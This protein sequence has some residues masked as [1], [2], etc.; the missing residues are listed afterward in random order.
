MAEPVQPTS[1]EEVMENDD[2][3]DDDVGE[4]S[5]E[6]FRDILVVGVVFLFPKFMTDNIRKIPVRKI[7]VK[8]TERRLGDETLILGLSGFG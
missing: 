4:S 3:I 8:T 1:P 7:R 2:L 6:D 5:G